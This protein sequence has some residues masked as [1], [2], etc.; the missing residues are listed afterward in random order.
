MEIW[1]NLLFFFAKKKGMYQHSNPRLKKPFEVLCTSLKVILAS[2]G[3]PMSWL[4]NDGKG[5]WPSFFFFFL[6]FF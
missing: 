6:S 2:N 4:E 5:I 3:L 1:L